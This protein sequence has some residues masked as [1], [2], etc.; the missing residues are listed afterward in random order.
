MG[1]QSYES[2]TTPV[3]PATRAFL[4]PFGGTS[5]SSGSSSSNQVTSNPSFDGNFVFGWNVYVTSAFMMMLLGLP[6]DFR[7]HVQ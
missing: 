2:I 3:E 6:L 4:R 1:C 7:S 5:S